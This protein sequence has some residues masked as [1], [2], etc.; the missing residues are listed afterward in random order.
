MERGDFANAEPILELE[1]PGMMGHDSET[2]LVIADGLLRCRLDRG[3]LS[4][5]LEPA[6]EYARL[7]RSGVTTTGDIDQVPPTT[8]RAG[9]SE[10][11]P[12]WDER[13]GLLPYLPPVWLQGPSFEGAASRLADRSASPDVELDLI[14]ELYRRS[15]L[16]EQ[17]VEI[18][19]VDL[20][21]EGIVGRPGP[22]LMGH[23]VN[24]LHP[25]ADVRKAARA[26]LDRRSAEEPAWV[27]TWS[28]FQL[29]RSYLM[30][31]GQGQRRKGMLQLVYLITDSS[32]AH[33]YLAGMAMAIMTDEFESQGD[34]AAASR[35]RADL[36]RAAPGHPV[37]RTP[38]TPAGVPGPSGGKENP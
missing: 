38:L 23:M 17:G 18:E 8:V 9:T 26:K 30:E 25:D 35:L 14:A 10:V 15:M 32:D 7:R 37:L 13:Y 20:G 21:V 27:E 1:F 34:Q 19:P 22:T 5:A 24:A 16:L 11:I 6:L 28:R 3:M 33:P 29:G 36:E 31:S 2:A 12:M 4:S